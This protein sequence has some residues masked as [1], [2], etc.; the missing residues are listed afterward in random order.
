[1]LVFLFLSPIAVI[2]ERLNPD[3]GKLEMSYSKFKRKDLSKLGQL[4][5]KVNYDKKFFNV[6]LALCMC[7]NLLMTKYFIAFPFPLLA[8]N[9]HQTV[10]PV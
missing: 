8:H 10:S 1:M 6:C 7:E 4:I 9:L 5:M 2:N 3:T